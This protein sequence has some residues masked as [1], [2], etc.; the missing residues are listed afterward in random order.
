MEPPR[1]AADH[2]FAVVYDHLRT[3]ARRELRRRRGGTLDTTALVNEAYLK[4]CQGPAKA[5]RDRGHFLAV[6]SLA[7]RH[8]LVDAARRRAMKR[9]RGETSN[10]GAP[11]EPQVAVDELAAEIIDLDQALAT[12]SA[13]DERLGRLVELRFFGG[14]SVEDTARALEVSER[15]VKRDWQKARAFLF[16]ALQEQR[17]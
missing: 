8:I 5:F 11:G 14:L 3:V 13:L 12:L 9:R 2:L 6:A 17:P 10:D 1:A 7:M 15:T 16:R 4:L